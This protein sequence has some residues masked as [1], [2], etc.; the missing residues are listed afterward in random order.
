MDSLPTHISPPIPAP[1]QSYSSLL[2]HTLSI[3]Q[4]QQ[5]TVVFDSFSL[6]C[7]EETLASPSHLI[8]MP[9]SFDNSIRETVAG[10]RSIPAESSFFISLRQPQTS[11]IG[12]DYRRRYWVDGPA[13]L[14]E[15]TARASKNQFRGDFQ[16]FR[17][18]TELSATCDVRVAGPSRA[19]TAGVKAEKVDASTVHGP[20][21]KREMSTGKRTAVV[22]HQK[23]HTSSIVP[24]RGLK[25]SSAVGQEPLSP[26]RTPR[27][28]RLPTPDLLP[29][30]TELFCECCMES[31][32]ERSARIADEM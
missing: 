31:T 7:A 25:S 3:R 22:I 9:E 12:R 16:L 32:R 13:V 29:L 5:P 8:T 6:T 19:P 1:L 18:D 21:P 23:S 2:Q 30:K 10:V 11:P 17:S 20:C 24:A 26:P 14:I 4:D 28:K 27:F 15:E